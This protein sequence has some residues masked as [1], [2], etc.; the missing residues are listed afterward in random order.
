MC[1]ALRPDVRRRRDD[2]VRRASAAESV[3]DV[4]A[5]AS[6][7]LR[8]MVPHDASAWLTTD[9]GTGF[10]TAPSRIEGVSASADLCTQHW[11]Q[12]FID[13]DVNR[14]GDLA[15]SAHP[16]AALRATAIDPHRSPRFRRFL[17]PLG[18]GDELRGVLRVGDAPWGTVTLW[19]RE[20]HAAFSA[21]ETDLVAS[22][23]APLGEALRRQVRTGTAPGV[24]VPLEQPGLFVFNERGQLVSANEYATAWL[25]ELPPGNKLPTKLGMQLPVWLVITAVRAF[26]SL[27]AG[28]DGTTRTRVQSRRGRWLVG[29][30][31]CTS[32]GS[33]APASTAVVVE[34]ASPAVIAPILIEAYGLTEREQ[35]V[36]REIARGAGTDEIA[37]TLYLSPHTVRDHIKAILTKVG[38]SSRAELVATLFAEH[39]EPVH[40]AAGT[41]ETVA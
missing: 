20:G 33:G 25:D 38:V 16:A 40:L 11:R 24:I 8:T 19:R 6:K 14:F 26:D 35:E 36:T 9:P 31:A 17:Q 3:T 18:F 7:Q 10:P 23:S 34:P 32:D 15:N 13:E 41:R 21:A 29:Y 2:L 27:V 1:A 39:Y 28:G 4:F 30:A 22:L 37:R 5:V 12:E